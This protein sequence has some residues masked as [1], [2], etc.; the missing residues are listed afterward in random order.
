MRYCFALAALA[1]ALVAADPPGCTN[2]TGWWCCEYTNVTQ[3]GNIIYSSADYGTGEGV[4]DG[5]NI[6][7][8]F[9][10][11]ATPISG[12]LD[13]A[14]STITW[15][16]DATWTR[17][18]PPWPGPAVP[19]PDYA[20]NLTAIYEICPRAY[21]SPNGTGDGSG[22]GTFASLT[23]R[24]P[25]LASLGIN[26]IWLAGYSLATAHFYGVWS[27]YAAKEPDQLDP[28]LG[29]SADFKALV[30]AAHA[31]GIRVFL[32]VIG[33]GLTNDSSIVAQHPEWFSGGSWGMTDYNYATG[34]ETGFA[35]WWTQL[36]LN[37]AVEY[38]VDG[39]RVDIADPAWWPTFDLAMEAINS[40]GREF[41]IFGEGSRYHFSQHDEFGPTN[42]LVARFESNPQL[43]YETVQFSC[44]DS[45][46][47]SGPGNYFAIKGSRA[48]L[49]YS[50]ILSPYI[51]L[52]LGGEEYDEDPVTDL[53]NLQ[54]D[55][56]GQSGKAGG[57]MYG[58]V[59]DPSQIDTNSSKSD[60]L[61]DTSAL[62]AL[63]KQHSDVLHKNKCE[64]NVT[65]VN[66]APAGAL[67]LVPY[68]R[69]VTG[70]Q[71]IAVFANTDTT[72]TVNVT[73]QIPLAA[74]GFDPGYSGYAV[75]VIY[76]NPDGA[77]PAQ[78][79]T[80]AQLQSWPVSIGPDG[81]RNGGVTALWIT[82]K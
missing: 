5:F 40:T 70:N 41:L 82:L 4:I 36:W 44:H 13:A 58:S 78:Q 46:W 8:E 32:D 51:P 67:S 65:R 74:M 63:V 2:L 38:G 64:S 29:S 53:P 61:A 18:A 27:V 10:N 77:N 69:F 47:E 45:G 7:M 15:S 57:W 73:A 23:A 12:T 22:S 3:A 1:S 49:A 30:D 37:Y 66:Y 54:M 33:H 26:S 17:S 11:N 24:V 42:D 75:T 59:R 81:Q 39:M 56:Y 76:P 72:N 35:A 60:M 34:V 31:A 71:A 20:R 79:A 25:Y 19:I 21:T 16:N 48:N 28:L 6:L 50:G 62:L 55:L 43:C 52:W 80:G 9:S 14:C 68:V